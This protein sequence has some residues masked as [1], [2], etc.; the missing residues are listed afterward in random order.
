MCLLWGAPDVVQCDNGTEFRNAIVESLF[1]SMGVRVRTGAV[2]HPQSQG[3]AERANW[4]LIGLIRK[5]LDSSSS[6]WKADLR[7]LLF[8]YRNRPHSVTRLSPMEAMVGWKPAHLVVDAPAPIMTASQWVDKLAKRSATIRD[9]LEEELSRSDGPDA[10]MPSIYALGDRVMLRRP[11]RHQKRKSP[12]ERGWCVQDVISASTVLVR[13]L[14]SG[15]E[16]VVNVELLKRDPPSDAAAVEIPDASADE[17]CLVFDIGQ[18]TTAIQGRYALRDSSV[19]RRPSR[20][21]E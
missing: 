17:P 19:L 4:T 16:K 9:M 3:A 10:T 21:D 8:F 11:D 15:A 1:Q 14:A 5:V 12:F 6:D 2:R 20:F 18:P 13:N 7:T